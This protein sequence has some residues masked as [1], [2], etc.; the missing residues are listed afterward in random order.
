M[1]T[2]RSYSFVVMGS[3]GNDYDMLRAPV[4]LTTAPG[5]GVKCRPLFA[6]EYT[7]RNYPAAVQGAFHNGHHEAAHFC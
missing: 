6:D 5:Q 2:C 3:A 1:W 4:A 7:I